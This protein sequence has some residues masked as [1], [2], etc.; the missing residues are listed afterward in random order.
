[1][2]YWVICLACDHKEKVDL[3][4]GEEAV[5]LHIST[6]PPSCRKCRS[7]NVRTEKSLG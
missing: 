1:M 3:V 5:R 4:P 6:S 7:S 2:K